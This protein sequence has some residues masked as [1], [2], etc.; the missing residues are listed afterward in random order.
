M[1]NNRRND[2]GH[3][4]GTI[5]LIGLIGVILAIFFTGT[6]NKAEEADLRAHNNEK[7]VAVTTTR[8]EAIQ[9]DI[10]EIKI[11]QKAVSLKID[12]IIDLVK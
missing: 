6:Y 12:K 2:V 4:I 1:E 5:I 11:E 7:D 3:K 10:V 8:V 9:D